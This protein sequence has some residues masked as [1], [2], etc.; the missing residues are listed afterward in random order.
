[1]PRFSTYATRTS[2][3]RKTAPRSMPPARRVSCSSRPLM[4]SR[5]SISSALP[6]YTWSFRR[7]ATSSTHKARNYALWLTSPKPR[8]IT[9]APS[10]APSK[11]IASPSPTPRPAKQ[12][13]KRSFPA[14]YTAKWSA[15]RNFPSTPAK[16][17][18][19]NYLFRTAR[20]RVSGPLFFAQSNYAEF[21]LL[22][23]ESTARLPL[24]S[25]SHSIEL[26][27]VAI[28]FFESLL[29]AMSM[30]ERSKGTTQAPPPLETSS[31][32]RNPSAKERAWEKNTLQPALQ[33]S[34]ERQSEF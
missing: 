17:S 27:Y 22:R 28:R 23:T 33:K 14:P 4:P 12:N 3:L 1:M 11:S 7:N 19:G 29:G 21:S 2:P 6:L 8:P 20:A 24:P 30:S 31:T 18:S 32:E 16:S 13:A 26:G 9:S 5:K 25:L 15:Q 10:G 34:P